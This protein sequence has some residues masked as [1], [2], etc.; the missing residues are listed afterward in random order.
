DALQCFK[1]RKYVSLDILDECPNDSIQFFDRKTPL[2][3][4][5]LRPEEMNGHHHRR[6]KRI[7][8]SKKGLDSF[9][10]N[11]RI[12][13]KP[14]SLVPPARRETNQKR[15]VDALLL[16]NQRLSRREFK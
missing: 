10:S 16:E 15:F 1:E 11:R 5:L 6:T 9:E 3:I 12:H 14:H 8:I 4:I 2:Q 13:I 7:N